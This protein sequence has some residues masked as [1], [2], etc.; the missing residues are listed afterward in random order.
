[1][2]QRCEI[3]ASAEATHFCSACGKWLCESLGCKAQAGFK[4]AARAPLRA[5]AAAPQFIRRELG[6]LLPGVGPGR[7]T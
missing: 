3:C 5:A 6:R 2:T 1:M 7:F 4:A